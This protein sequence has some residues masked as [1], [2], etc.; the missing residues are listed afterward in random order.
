VVEGARCAVHP[1]ALA[2]AACERCGDFACGACLASSSFCPRCRPLAGGRW[3]AGRKLGTLGILWHALGVFPR[4]VEAVLA[5]AVVFVLF[6]LGSYFVSCWEQAQAS[7]A[8]SA[9]RW[10]VLAIG[11]FGLGGVAAIVL[12]PLVIAGTTARAADVILR[13]AQPRSIVRGGAPLWGRLVLILTLEVMATGLV[14]V[15]IMLFFFPMA[16][17]EGEALVMNV[18]LT[19]TPIP[20]LIL[21][22]LAEA[23]AVVDDAGVLPAIGRAW[24]FLRTR[25]G[26]V[27]GLFGVQLALE[28]ALWGSEALREAVVERAPEVGLPLALGAGV[29]QAASFVLWA[30]VFAAFWLARSRLDETTTSP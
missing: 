15:P 1:D 8:A 27:A 12:F 25:W 18:S 3:E 19:V 24:R 11:A 13:R 5:L 4:F 29:F 10:I 9:M 2:A 22:S 23:A 14:T 21:F 28:G 20:I 7:S 30:I 17:S 26:D 16:Q 6:E